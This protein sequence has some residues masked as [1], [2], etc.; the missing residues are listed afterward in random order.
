[1]DFSGN[2]GK[3]I[4]DPSELAMME[5]EQQTSWRK[6]LVRSH[7]PNGSYHQ[8]QLKHLNLKLYSMATL[9]SS[10]LCDGGLSLPQLSVKVLTILLP[11]LVCVKSQ[12]IAIDHY[13]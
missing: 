11:V 9:F 8:G 5:L 7:M 10:K 2:Q 4:S 3:V 12:L 1:M 13:W 6:K